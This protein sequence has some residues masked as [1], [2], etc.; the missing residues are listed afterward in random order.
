MTK[1]SEPWRA[2]DDTEWLPVTPDGSPGWTGWQP[3]ED[4]VWILT[5]QDFRSAYP[6]A[7]RALADGAPNAG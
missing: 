5:E 2:S 4:G 1:A 7:P 6:D 3:G